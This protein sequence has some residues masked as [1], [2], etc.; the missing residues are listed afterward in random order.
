MWPFTKPKP[1]PRIPDHDFD[2]R[3]LTWRW[4][5]GSCSVIDLISVDALLEHD[6]HTYVYVSG[7]QT[8][9]PVSFSV[10]NS[11]WRSAKDDTTPIP[12][13]F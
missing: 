3:Y 7:R 2:G 9:V 10:L 1:T 5:D 8:P 6:S 4:F 12:R 11:Y 13:Q